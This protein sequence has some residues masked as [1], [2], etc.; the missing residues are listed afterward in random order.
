MEHCLGA[1]KDP[2]QSLCVR[3]RMQYCIGFVLRVCYSLISVPREATLNCLGKVMVIKEVPDDWRKGNFTSD[4]K[5]DNA[6]TYRQISLTSL[7][8]PWEGGG[9]NNPGNH[10]QAYEGQ[11]TWEQ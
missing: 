8:S 1:D 4:F 7:G 9:A 5:K 6:E 10:F 11:G 3:I 2:V